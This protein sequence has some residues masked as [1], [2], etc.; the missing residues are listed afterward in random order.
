MRISMGRH[1]VG[2]V[3]QS[4]SKVRR[5][6]TRTD[7]RRQHPAAAT[8]GLSGD[9]RYHSNPWA[10]GCSCSSHGRAPHSTRENVPGRSAYR[11][12]SPVRKH[13]PVQNNHPEPLRNRSQRRFAYA[14]ALNVFTKRPFGIAIRTAPSSP[15]PFLRALMV[16]TFGP[17]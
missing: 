15:S 3:R 8:Q 1:D 17:G 4:S 6:Y 10:H 16:P 2:V 12:A 14:A 5:G 11:V 9:L 7:D 13:R